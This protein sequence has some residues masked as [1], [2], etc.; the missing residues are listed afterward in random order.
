MIFEGFREVYNKITALWDGRDNVQ[1][2]RYATLY[3]SR[4][5]LLQSSG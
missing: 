2:G 4:N 5:L 1:S 3:G